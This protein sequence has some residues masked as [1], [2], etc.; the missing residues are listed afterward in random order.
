MPQR[1]VTECSKYSNMQKKT[2]KIK[3]R[4]SFSIFFFFWLISFV[5]RAVIKKALFLM[6]LFLRPKAAVKNYSKRQTGERGSISNF[7][8]LLCGCCNLP[9]EAAIFLISFDLSG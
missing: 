6:W 2:I 9:S 5:L 8:C 7:P 3:A 4:T 1:A